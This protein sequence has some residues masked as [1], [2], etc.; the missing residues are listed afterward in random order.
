MITGR[1]NTYANFRFSGL[2]VWLDFTSR[3]GRHGNAMA[4]APNYTRPYC[5]D[6]PRRPLYKTRWLGIHLG[7]VVAEV[8]GFC[9]QKVISQGGRFGWGCTTAAVVGVREGHRFRFAS[10]LDFRSRFHL[11]ISSMFIPVFILHYSHTTNSYAYLC[12]V[13][14]S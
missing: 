14:T 7:P 8:G 11:Y 5:G 13:S 3:L 12:G 4:S 1:P 9:P 6:A 2:P 10:L